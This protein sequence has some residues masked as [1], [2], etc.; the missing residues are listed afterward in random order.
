MLTAFAWGSAVHWFTL[1]SLAALVGAVALDLL[2]LPADVTGVLSARKRVRRW[3]RLC[4]VVLILASLSEL[5]LRA[6]TM[7][8]ATLT[9]AVTVIPTVLART[10]FGSIWIA[11]LLALAIVIA[12]S[13]SHTRGG[14]VLAGVLVA[15]L[16]LTTSLTGHAGDA[17]DFSLNVLIDWAHVLG[18]GAWV[19]GLLGLA[20]VASRQYAH[21]PPPLVAAVA[22]R[23]ST[24]AGLGLVVVVA[25]GAYNAWVQLRAVS[26]L[27][28]TFYGRVLAAKIVLVVLLTWLGAVNRYAVIPWLG[29][30]ARSRGFGVRLFRVARL[31]I[32]GVTHRSRRT[33]PARLF[34][35]VAREAALGL[36]IFGCTAVLTESTPARHERHLAHDEH[37][38]VEAHPMRVTMEE[39]HE[40]GGVPKRWMFTPPGGNAAHGRAIFVSLECFACHTVQGEGF[41]APRR[42]GPDLTGMGAHHP[43]GYLAES[44]MNP[45]AVI[46]EGPG[47][48][49]PDGLSI[50][51]DYRD[52]LTLSELIDL[53]AYLKT[54]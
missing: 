7:T 53:V 23:F 41:P 48:T 1:V 47:Y 54:I 16:G 34:R 45:N 42:Q 12:S 9:A 51:P 3:I 38:E 35:N 21:W 22:R 10:H 2:V 29:D 18:S 37:T 17:G 6:Q 33:R 28:T 24:L 36:V 5:A 40:R 11:R 20:F 13:S 15:G 30:R 19:G 52:N 46:V 14:R 27:W 49:G 8:G 26:A 39:L 43:P 44:V 4:A 32:R 50:M 25:S 31:V